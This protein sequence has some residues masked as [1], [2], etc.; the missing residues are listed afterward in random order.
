MKSRSFHCQGTSVGGFVVFVRGQHRWRRALLCIQRR[1]PLRMILLRVSGVGLQRRGGSLGWRVQ[2]RSLLWLF[3]MRAVCAN[4]Q[5]GACV[6]KRW[7]AKERRGIGA[8][9]KKKK[10]N[11]V[12]KERGKK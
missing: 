1:G 2:S 12:K 4:K 11:K 10:E 6:L 9:R 3:D 7:K 5:R 8:R